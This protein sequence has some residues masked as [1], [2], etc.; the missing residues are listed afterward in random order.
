[1]PYATL[2]VETPNGKKIGVTDIE[3]CILSV[4]TTDGK[5]ISRFP[6]SDFSMPK[7]IA[8]FH[9]TLT[10]NYGNMLPQAKINELTADAFQVTTSYVRDCV[11]ANLKRSE[12]HRAA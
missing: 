6:A 7:T 8:L 2:Y 10:R 3:G 1:M 5:E 9:D 12:V 11:R 4:Q